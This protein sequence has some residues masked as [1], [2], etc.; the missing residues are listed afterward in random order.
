MKAHAGIWREHT[1]CS[2]V[3]V[4]FVIAMDRVWKR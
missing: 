3:D 1:D 2:R 4:D